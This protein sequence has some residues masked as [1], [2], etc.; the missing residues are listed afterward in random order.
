MQAVVFYL[1]Y[2]FIYLVASLPMSVL[3]K[4]SDVC[5]HL[6]RLSGYRKNVILTNPR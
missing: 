3:Y 6:M 5:Y 2:P 4:V 1:I